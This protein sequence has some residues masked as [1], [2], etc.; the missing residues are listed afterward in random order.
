MKTK[1][2]SC[3]ICERAYSNTADTA[4]CE[5]DHYRRVFIVARE[6]IHKALRQGAHIVIP[7]DLWNDL[8]VAYS[9]IDP[10]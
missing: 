10:A 4:R 1:T 9:V 5:R 8:L 6:I 7:P 2:T 3:S